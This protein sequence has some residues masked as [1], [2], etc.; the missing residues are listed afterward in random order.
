MHLPSVVESPWLVR[1]LT[2]GKGKG[3]RVKRAENKI[4]A[5]RGNSGYEQ[6][7]TSFF[8]LEKSISGDGG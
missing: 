5:V 4:S 2:E 1:S 7:F 6:S 3:K 8:S